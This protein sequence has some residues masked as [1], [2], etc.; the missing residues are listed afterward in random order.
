MAI[1]KTRKPTGYEAFNHLLKMPHTGA[2]LLYGYEDGRWY[3]NGIVASKGDWVAVRLLY[4]MIALDPSNLR[5]A[6][7]ENAHGF[8]K[9]K[10]GEDGLRYMFQQL[11]Q[12]PKSQKSFDE[13]PYSKAVRE[14]H[15]TLNDGRDEYEDITPALQSG[16]VSSNWR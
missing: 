2:P 15:R 1:A 11:T 5:I 9:H 3:V 13:N 10:F 8:Y 6:E 7:V 14:L 4:L 16:M 12:D